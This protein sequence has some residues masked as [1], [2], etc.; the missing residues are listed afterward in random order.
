M[1]Q[2]L[3]IPTANVDSV[4]LAGVLASA[5]T[6]IYAGWATVGSSPQVGGGVEQ[7][8]EGGGVKSGDV[9]GGWVGGVWGTGHKG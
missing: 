6:G 5:V 3:G 2:D 7:A 4:A 9:K 1:P 8:W